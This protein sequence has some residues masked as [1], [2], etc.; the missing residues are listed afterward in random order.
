MEQKAKA[1]EELQNET[2]LNYIL[3]EYRTHQPWQSTFQLRNS[4][5]SSLSCPVDLNQKMWHVW[6]KPWTRLV[7]S[8]GVEEFEKTSRRLV[9][10][11]IHRIRRA[12]W[13][14]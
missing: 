10:T 12:N 3:G 6:Y 14:R 4:I 13:F 11:T 5:V 9:E 7:T 8:G 1:N 2:L